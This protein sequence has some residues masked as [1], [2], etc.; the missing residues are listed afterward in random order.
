[1]SD[2]EKGHSIVHLHPTLA[3][4][5][6]CKHCYSVSGP[7]IGKKG[8]EAEKVI[9]YLAY[10]AKE[11]GFNVL[12]IS[13][14]EPFLYPDLEKVTEHAIELGYFVQVVSNGTLFGSARIKR[15][16]SKINSIAI[17]IDGDE[18]LHNEMR[19][20]KL[21]FK[22]SLDG[23]NLLND[24]GIPFGIIHT[25]TKQSWQKI[26]DLLEFAVL[27]GAKL[28]QLH[29]LELAGR[30]SGQ[31]QMQLSQSDLHKLYILVS[32]LQGTVCEIDIHLDLTHKVHL[33]DETQKLVGSSENVTEIQDLTRDLIITESGSVLPISY[34]FSPDFEI[35]NILSGEDPKSSIPDFLA[36]KGKTL[37]KLIK[38]ARKKV[39]DTPEI[40]LFNL[41]EYLVVQSHVPVSTTGLEL[42]K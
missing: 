26:P 16:L 22:K 40:D 14:G 20:S 6:K 25:V 35:F 23:I 5:L 34:G 7:G 32:A 17:S 2:C 3:C 31:S 41:T 8:L 30:A 4:N 24:L 9:A 11:H 18:Q 1:M 12:S 28:L 19:D 13:G 33:T 37:Q 27:H 38:N 36:N 21:A 29:P 42:V 15:I 10:L 39:I